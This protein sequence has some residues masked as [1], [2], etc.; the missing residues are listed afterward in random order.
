MNL[1][2]PITVRAPSF[3]KNGKQ[4]DF[5]P[6]MLSTFNP[7]LIDDGK[8]VVA[9]CAFLPPF[10]VFEGEEYTSLGDWTQAQAEQRINEILTQDFAQNLLNS[11][12]SAAK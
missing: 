7:V 11:R 3:I 4:V 10:V 2:N 5:P 9:R 12:V 6:A 8:K 1:S